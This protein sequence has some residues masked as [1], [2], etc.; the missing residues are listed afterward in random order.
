MNWARGVLE[1]R[2]LERE[3]AAAIMNSGDDQLLGVLDAAFLIRRHYFGHKV[4]LHYLKNAKSGMCGENCSYC[5]QSSVSSA[6]IDTYSLLD[7]E[8]LVDGARQARAANANTYCMAASGRA[9]SQSELEHIVSAVKQIKSETDLHVCCSLGTLTFQQAQRLKNAG[10]DRIN[11]NLNTSRRFHQSICTTHSY[12][13][14]L[15]T[16]RAA[17]Q[18]GLELCAGLIVGM[19]ETTDDL[20]DVA[21]ELGNIRVESIPV[22]FLHAIEGT[23][24]QDLDE[25]DPRYCLR[26]LCLFRFLNPHTEIRIAGGRE[27]HLRSLQAMGLYP[28][29]SIFVSDYLTTEGQAAE[30]DFQMIRDLGFEIVMD[31]HKASEMFE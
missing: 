31:A 27:I 18:A 1:G 12:V 16:L 17:R 3:Q 7:A 21:L 4:L 28:A 20:I 6:P 5:S 25:L 11:H 8:Q 22:N 14:R 29:N 9:P 10:V 23:P 19:G 13:D 24:L 2:S 26:A 30:A 15:Q